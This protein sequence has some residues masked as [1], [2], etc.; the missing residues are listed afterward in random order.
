M[1]TREDRLGFGCHCSWRFHRDNHVQSAAQSVQT[2]NSQL[3]QVTKGRLPAEL[4]LWWAWVSKVQQ[5]ASVTFRLKVLSA[6]LSIIAQL[7]QSYY[8]NQVIHN[9]GTLV[10]NYYRM[11]NILRN[12]RVCC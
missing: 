3:S 6:N 5:S 11:A 9:V 12:R 10:T 8:N 4:P 7:V 1:R 2:H